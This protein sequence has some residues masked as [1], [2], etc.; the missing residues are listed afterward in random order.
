[1]TATSFQ[2]CAEVRGGR[3]QFMFHCSKCDAKHHIDVENT[4][5]LSHFATDDKNIAYALRAT[6]G[7]L[8]YVLGKTYAHHGAHVQQ[9]AATS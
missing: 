2:C 1:M 8:G 5:D 3:D 9:Q 7:E 4:V 6:Q